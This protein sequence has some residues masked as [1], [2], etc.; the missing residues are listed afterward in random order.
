MNAKLIVSIIGAVIA[1]TGCSDDSTKKTATSAKDQ[2]T[3]SKSDNGQNSSEIELE[4]PEPNNNNDTANIHIYA[5][6]L[7]SSVQAENINNIEVCGQEKCYPATLSDTQNTIGTGSQDGTAQI[8]ANA[9]VSRETITS[10]KVS[11]K[12]IGNSDRLYETKQKLIF[13]LDLKEIPLDGNI[14]MSIRENRC[15][16]GQC[17][18]LVSADA[19]YSRE[20]LNLA[21]YSPKTG[22]KKYVGNGVSIDIPEGAIDQARIFNINT[23]RPIAKYPQVDIYPYIELKKKA[24]VN[25]D[26]RRTDKK[27]K[28]AVIGDGQ[29]NDNRDSFS[30]EIDR[31]SNILDGE[32]SPHPKDKGAANTRDV[33]RISECISDLSSI[34]ANG[35]E[36]FL[37]ISKGAVLIRACVK[38]PPYIYIVVTDNWPEGTINYDLTFNTN[39]NS[40]GEKSL[41][42]TRV[43]EYSDYRVLIN[44]FNWT[45]GIINGIGALPGSTGE[46]YGYVK[47]IEYTGSGLAENG[48]RHVIG[49]NSLAGGSTEF[50]S[51]D[52]NNKCP[53][54]QDNTTNMRAL[55]FLGD[56]RSATWEDKNGY[57]EFWGD[58]PVVLSSTTSIIK[59]GA[60]PPEGSMERW[61]AFGLT[62]TGR[63]IFVS[64]ATDEPTSASELCRVFSTLGSINAIRLDGGSSAS[65]SY[66]GELLNPL[67]GVRSVILGEARRVGYVFGVP[68]KLQ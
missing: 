39:I 43:N 23:F 33:E 58:R 68:G 31:T 13:P 19:I 65:M 47:G 34:T 61:S 41:L 4:H 45:G 7:E 24:T 51:T 64:S 17:I 38:K 53:P 49:A 44:G 21:F 22:L 46:A 12:E 18:D 10:V 54:P 26:L 16:N 48:S 3:L 27:I 14:L 8:L 57:F 42:L 30:L 15:T 52:I 25:F 9:K 60:C 6:S 67:Q 59:E 37:Q 28:G 29:P 32:P 55:S 40:R 35:I 1:L 36:P 66:Y 2:P 5:T 56:R 11:W 62:P 20:G 63:G 50:C